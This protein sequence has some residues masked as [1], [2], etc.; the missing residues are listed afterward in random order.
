M[1]Q[2]RSML[3]ASINII[4]NNDNKNS[5]YVDSER[6]IDK[7]ICQCIDTLVN[8]II[9]YIINNSHDNIPCFNDFFILLLNIIDIDALVSK[10][11]IINTEIISKL[12][13]ITNKCK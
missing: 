11:F 3:L 7:L 9:T 8:L 5:L 2:C 10:Y 6:I 13:I 4:F 1:K 12:L